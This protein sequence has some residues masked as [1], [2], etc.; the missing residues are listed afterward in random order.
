MPRVGILLPVGVQRTFRPRAHSFGRYYIP[1]AWV[2]ILFV[3]CTGFSGP[4]VTNEQRLRY[5]AFLFVCQTSM[6]FNLS[7]FGYLTDNTTKSNN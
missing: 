2:S 7:G 5:P 6:M 1:T 4:K 3:Y